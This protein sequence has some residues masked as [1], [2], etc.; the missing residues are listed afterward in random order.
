MFEA[1]T[2]KNKDSIVKLMILFLCSYSFTSYAQ[3]VNL[4]HYI[5]SAIKHSPLLQK[6][7][8]TTKIITLDL[9]QFKAI[10]KSP[11]VN[12]NSTIL[13]APIISKDG[14]TNKLQLTSSGST[15]YIGYDLGVSN[16]GQYQS[17]VSVSQPL[18]T[19]KY[20]KAYKNKAT[21]SKM[22]S[23]NN[24][25]LTKTELKQIVTHQYIL[26][27]QSKK[28][29][30]NTLITIKIIKDQVAQ[31]K[32]LVKVGIYKLVDLK[33]LEIE[34]RNVQLENVRLQTDYLT[35][36]NILNLISGINNS[37]LYELN[38]VNIKLNNPL[39]KIS[40]FTSQYKID[41][42]AV[43]TEQKINELTYLP[44]INALGDAGL[45]AAYTPSFN[46][47]GFSV[48]VSLNWNL[49]DG[50]QK[51][52]KK[53][54]SQLFIENIAIDKKYF[55]NQNNIRKNNL[56]NQINSLDK[57]LLLINNQLKEYRKLLQL[58]KVEIKN[59][60]IS[61]LE[62]KTLI[63]DISTKTQEKTNTLMTKEILINS[64]NYWNN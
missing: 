27:I 25:Q 5:N 12:L 37:T 38:D 51:Q 47:L 31:M 43:K 40:L 56:L 49:F 44:Q 52:L 20:Y 22:R 9:K 58:Y 19:N 2:A 10:Y 32:E 26:C 23:E 18:F 42:L 21:I 53:K 60:L 45:N 24:V 35:N 6:Q 8:N 39:K 17:L 41:S 50:H 48:G 7:K 64:Y 61:V 62:L 1:Y 28:Q 59:S 63:K 57:Q 54:Q 4:S 55:E 33:L 16:G 30:N 14:T 13:F 15:N 46:R 11:K 3:V 34:L 36:F 29:E